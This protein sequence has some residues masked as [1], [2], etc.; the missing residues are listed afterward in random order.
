MPI[1]EQEKS[2]Q[3]KVES[4]KTH[5]LPHQ[6]KKSKSKKTVEKIV[7]FYEMEKGLE[8]LAPTYPEQALKF[9]L[10]ASI[11][12]R[13]FIN[14]DG[15]VVRMEI[16]GNNKPNQVFIDVISEAVKSWEF[17][18]IGEDIV[19]VSEKELNFRIGED[20]R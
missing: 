11:N 12:I 20:V 1:A 16:L 6:T 10:E 15:R 19:R 18:K 7:P 2:K 17:T 3:K 14:S 13:I 5:E 8:L 4:D 9:G